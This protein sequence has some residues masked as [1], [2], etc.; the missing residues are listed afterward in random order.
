VHQDTLLA[1]GPPTTFRLETVNGDLEQ[2]LRMLKAG[3]CEL[4]LVTHR[5]SHAQQL[6]QRVD[7]AG[8]NG[9]RVSR[10]PLLE[11]AVR[12]CAAKDSPWAATCRAWT[13]RYRRSAPAA[14][15]AGPAPRLERRRASLDGRGGL[16]RSRSRYFWILPVEVLGSSV[17][18]TRFGTLKRAS[19]LRQNSMISASLVC[20]P[21]LSSTKAQGTS[22]HFASGSATTE[23]SITAGW[24]CSTSSTS[25]ELMFSPPEMMTSLLRSLILM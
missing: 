8:G 3:R 17:N 23:A 20:A 4:L 5:N 1:N 11:Q 25:T 7:E 9:L 12:L 22:P 21:G 18:T 6:Q 19:W 10:G 16:A 14:A 13:R 2:R 24:R 15:A